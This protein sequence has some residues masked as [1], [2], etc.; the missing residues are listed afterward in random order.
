[1]KQGYDFSKVRVIGMGNFTGASGNSVSG[2]FARQLLIRGYNVKTSVKEV[3]A[4][5][6]GSVDQYIPQKQYLFYNNSNSDANTVVV[7]PA[8]SEITGAN[9]Y[10]LGA[11][12]GLKDKGEVVISNATAGV[13]ARLI[14]AKTQEIIWTNSYTYESF[15]IKASI[16]NTVNYLVNS[17]TERK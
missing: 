13:T 1:M 4:V 12:F 10:S 15:D 3:D 11:P 5:L 8:V 14:D 17:F 2:E 7:V 6:E 16:E 9:T